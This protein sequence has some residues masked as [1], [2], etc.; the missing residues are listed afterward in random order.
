MALVLAING[1]Y[2]DD[3]VTDRAVEAIIG[4]LKSA[5]VTVEHVHL[6]DHPIEFCLNCRACTQQ[7]GESPGECVHNDG[8]RA[9]VDRIEQ[10][11]GY[12]LAAPTN[13]GSVTATFK[14]FM[15]RLIVYGYWP[16]G[17]PAP[18]FRKAKSPKKKA[19]LVSSCAAPG[20][21]GRWLY[22]AHKQ[23]RMTAEFIGAKPVGTLFTGLVAGQP[24]AGLPKRVRSRAQALAQKLI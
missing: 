13:L 9:L 5:G 6:R 1:S 17:A 16:W 23:L 11:D 21:M 22:S 8:M 12:I 4:E 24:E 15:E 3:G 20:L 10:A 7:P 19:I 18:V 14:R 2:R